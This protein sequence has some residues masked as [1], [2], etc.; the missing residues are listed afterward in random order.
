[1]TGIVN[2]CPPAPPPPLS[3]APS[4]Q[5]LSHLTIR[6]LNSSQPARDEN[7]LCTH[8]ALSASPSHGP[9]ASIVINETK[10]G[11]QGS[12]IR[13]LQP[14]GH[15][16]SWHRDGFF[17][18][19]DKAFV[20]PASVNDVFESDLMWWNDPLEPKQMQK[21]LENCMTLTIFAVPD[22]ADEMQSAS[23]PT[24]SLPRQSA[25]S[26]DAETALGAK[27][28]GLPRVTQQGPN[29]RLCGLARVVTDYVTFAYLTDVFVLE[30]FQRR[31]LASWMMRAL[32]ETVDEWPNLRGLMLM[33]H[34]KAAARMYQR[35][36]GAV[37]FDKGPSAG[38]VMLEMGGKGMKD[39]PDEH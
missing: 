9:N 35:E 17:L 29:F 37:D 23:Y 10:M 6:D 16:R 7:A 11:S 3:P 5:I 15:P 28:G 1:M 13:Q 36:L 31:G 33:T 32:K 21:M 27:N 18:T 30:D 8:L 38:L 14:E 24:A 39:V 4:T 22:T 34:D 20:D 26:K 12:V 19:T 25:P 2:T